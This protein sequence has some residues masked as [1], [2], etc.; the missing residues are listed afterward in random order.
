MS[1]FRKI[2]DVTRLDDTAI[3]SLQSSDDPKELTKI[4]AAERQINAAI[5]MFLASDD[6]LAV[7]TLGSAA[8]R[9]LRDLKAK[10]GKTELADLLS[11][12]AFNVARKI[13]NGELEGLPE[14]LSDES[15][16]GEMILELV[17][18]IK[19]GKLQGCNQVVIS[20]SDEKGHWRDYNKVANFLKHADHDAE[21]VLPAAAV[22]NTRLLEDACRCYAGLV[23]TVTSEMIAFLIW[24][25]PQHPALVSV[26]KDR[27]KELSAIEEEARRRVCLGLIGYFKGSD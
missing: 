12:I 15:E 6:E 18:G 5:R 27:G 21:A 22:R 23:G 24:S 16:L 10:Q 19:S 14:A 4:V 17:E 3:R 25:N 9:I 8:Y 26:V 13:V 2:Q 20:V 1:K 7:H 11:G